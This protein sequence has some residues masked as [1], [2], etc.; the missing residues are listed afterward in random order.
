MEILNKQQQ[1][2]RSDLQL[3]ERYREKEDMEALAVLFNRYT[4]QIYGVCLK[5][6]KH[7]QDSEDAVMSI[8]E[9]L[10]GKLKTHEVQYFKSWLY[11][12]SKNYCL[13]QLRKSNRTLTKENTAELMYSQQVFH[14]DNKDDALPLDTLNDCMGKL[15]VLQQKCTRLFYFEKN[16][17]NEIAEALKLSWSSVRSYIQNGRRN[18]KNCLEKNKKQ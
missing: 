2:E 11:I 9:I 8:F 13:E 18:L 14:P 1:D 10:V 16:S 17:Y 3:I 6:L 4:T 7:K 12:L 5:Y 15:P